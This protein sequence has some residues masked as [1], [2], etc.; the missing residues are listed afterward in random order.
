MMR[1]SGSILKKCSCKNKNSCPHGWTLRWWDKG[2]H[3]LTFSTKKLAMDKQADIWR[4]KRAGEETFST[5]GKTPFTEYL[6]G[7]IEGRGGNTRRGYEVALKRIRSDLEGKTL[8][9]VAEDREGVQRLVDSVPASYRRRVRTIIVGACNEAQRAGRIPPHRLLRLRVEEDSHR[10][11]FEYADRKQLEILASE[12]GDL[13]L[14][15]WTGRLAGLRIGESLGL[16]IA[17]FT[18]DGT[19]LR[20]SRQRMSNGTLG[21]LKSRKAGEFRDIP[22]PAALWAK[23]SEAPR[24]ENG[25][26]F[27]EIWTAYLYKRIRASRDKADLP[28]KFTAHW[29]RHM[30]ASDML[31]AGVPI[32]DVSRWLGHRDIQLTYATYSHFVP[33]AFERARELIDR[34]W[35]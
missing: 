26:L 18:E 22:V 21:P 15:V 1:G 23:V 2:Q 34:D 25:S 4:S 10:A 7:W 20:L 11:E 12:L 32:T 14:L 3:E 33:R 27:P 19:V 5:G 30:W 31:A 13:G 8:Q 29:L 16:N 9:Q 17:D 35:I 28:G 24:D 6:T